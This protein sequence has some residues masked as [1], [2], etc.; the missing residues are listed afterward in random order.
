MYYSLFLYTLNISLV[1]RAEYRTI[2]NTL[3]FIDF[4]KWTCTYICTH[5]PDDSRE[6][7]EGEDSGAGCGGTR[8][9]DERTV[10]VSCHQRGCRSV[11][12]GAHSMFSTYNRRF[13]Y[14]KRTF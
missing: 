10:L 14:L 4:T 5:R 11:L 6:A 12:L 9:W 1:N 7:R 13:K 8:S 3:S 2:S